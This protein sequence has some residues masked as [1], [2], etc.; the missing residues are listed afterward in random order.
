[1]EQSSSVEGLTRYQTDKNR[2]FLLHINSRIFYKHFETFF[3]NMHNIHQA[4]LPLYYNM[5]SLDYSKLLILTHFSTGFVCFYLCFCICLSVPFVGFF[6]FSPFCDIRPL[7]HSEHN[8][9]SGQQGSLGPLNSCNTPAVFLFL[10]SQHFFI[11]L[12]KHKF[13]WDFVCAYVFI[14]VCVC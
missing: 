5:I 8:L 12:V 13:V 4:H 1:M 2:Y 3:K 10:S 6:F 11:I 7:F 9:S 14:C